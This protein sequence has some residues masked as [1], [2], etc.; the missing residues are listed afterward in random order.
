IHVRQ[1]ANDGAADNDSSTG[2]GVVAAAAAAAVA[3]AAVCMLQL[4]GGGT[5]SLVPSD[6]SPPSPSLP[7]PPLPS[8]RVLKFATAAAAAAADVKCSEGPCS[9]LRFSLVRRNPAPS[10]ATTQPYGQLQDGLQG[11]QAAVMRHG[12]GG[13]GDDSAAPLLAELATYL[14]ETQR[15]DCLGGSAEGSAET[16]LLD[17]PTA[18]DVMRQLTDELRLRRRRIAIQ[19]PQPQPQAHTH[20]QNQQQAQGQP[21][22][23][24]EALAGAAG[25]AVPGEAA[26]AA[27]Q[28]AAVGDQLWCTAHQPRCAAEL[29]GNSEQV[30]RLRDWL[31]SWREVIT[32][33]GQRAPEGATGGGGGRKQRQQQRRLGRRRYGDEGSSESYFTDS[34]FEARSAGGTADSD[35]E[36]PGGGG[37]GGA[38]YKGLPTA[39]VLRGPSG[40]GKTA[41][42]YAVAS[43]LGFRVLEVNPSLDRSGSQLLRMVGEATK[44]RRLV[45]GLAAGGGGGAGAAAGGGGLVL[46][47]KGATTNATFAHVRDRR[48]G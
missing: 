18:E 40:C 47:A 46:G 12:G 30:G 14:V 32:Q 4:D 26:V 13:G 42:A 22:H 21:H 41:A 35:G 9:R 48:R 31:Q 25:T 45:Q 43:E 23:Q 16:E 34:D 7:S 29:C 19:P 38:Q 15:Q 8:A 20:T 10:A 6:V 3:A 17:L 27:P 11:L 39:V 2:S 28:G 37:G 1:T 44:S 5:L 24:V 36:G 33:E